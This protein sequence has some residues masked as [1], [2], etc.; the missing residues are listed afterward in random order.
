MWQLLRTRR[1][2]SFTAL[3]AFVTIAFGLLSLWQWHRAEDKRDQRIELLNALAATPQPLNEVAGGT[4]SAEDEFRH[5]TITGTYL[6]NTEA[7]VRKRPLDAQNGFWAMTALRADDGSVVWINRGWLPTAGDALS[8]PVVAPPPGGTVDVVGYLRSFETADPDANSGLPPG[9]IAA[10][11]PALLP[12]MSNTFD[13]YIQLQNSA[14][15]QE[16]LKT[17]PVPEL[18]ESRNISYALQFLLFAF[19][20]I[21]GWFFFLR[22][23]AIDDAKIAAVAAAQA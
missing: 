9:Q 7:V 1:W 3:V 11:A 12:T 19:V 15:A 2:R 4:V 13:G 23:E 22:R 6:P 18:D 16:G 14:P 21:G 5:V 10:V 17:L 20:A 8:T